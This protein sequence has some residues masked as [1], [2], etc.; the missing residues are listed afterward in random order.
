MR[1]QKD[2][3]HHGDLRQALIE[4]AIELIAQQDVSSVSLREVARR[5]GVSHTAPYRHFADKDALLAAL[6]EEGFR[7]LADALNRA[8]KQAAEHPL[9]RLEASGVAYVEYAFAHPS[10]YRVMFGRYRSKELSNDSLQEC[11]TN[12]VVLTASQQVFMV[13]VN[14]VIEGQDKGVIRSGEPKQLAWVAW[15]LVHGLAML[16]IDAQLPLSNAADIVSMANFM[17]KTLTQGLMK[18]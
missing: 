9:R 8:I 17:T 11:D 3:Y 4:A 6:A 13:L 7:G 2:S 12:S 14:I 15:S 10:H 5:V 1:Q 18:E 16:L